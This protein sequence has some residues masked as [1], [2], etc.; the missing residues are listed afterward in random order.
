MKDPEPVLYYCG[1]MPFW[2]DPFYLVRGEP[3]RPVGVA[4]VR[5]AVREIEPGRAVYQVAPLTESMDLALSQPRM[6]TLLVVGFAATALLLAA[7]G[8]YGMLAQFVAQRRREIGVRMAL[9]ARPVQVLGQVLRQ[10]A[11]VVAAGLAVGIACALVLT[12]FLGS[13]VWGIPARDP[14][15]FLGV[16]LVLGL[17]AAAASI[18]PARRAVRVDP[19]EALRDE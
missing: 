3:Q 2:P 19:V 1:L 14:A 18:L 4:A 12:R 15:T 5:A 8:L 16:A 13:L 17:V 9:G 7:L 11:S 6:N 10:A